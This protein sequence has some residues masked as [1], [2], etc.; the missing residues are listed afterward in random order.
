MPAVSTALITK[1]LKRTAFKRS[2]GNTTRVCELVRRSPL[3]STKSIKI[4]A[5]GIRP[6]VSPLPWTCVLSREGPKQQCLDQAEA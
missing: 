5:V 6:D 3:S 4:Y 1:T 2:K